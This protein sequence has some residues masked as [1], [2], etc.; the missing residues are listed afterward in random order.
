MSAAGRYLVQLALTIVLGAR[1]RPDRY[2][3]ASAWLVEGSGLCDR[4]AVFLPPASFA[5]IPIILIESAYGVWRFRT[6]AKPTCAAMATANCMST[7]IG[8][9]VMWVVTMWL[10][11]GVLRLAAIVRSRCIGMRRHCMGDRGGS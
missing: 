4:S 8:L 3:D 5:L 2:T 9:P 11:E 6:A 10:V 1:L 7:L